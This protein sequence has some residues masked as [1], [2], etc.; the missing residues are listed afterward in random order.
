M[1]HIIT[2]TTTHCECL[3]ETHACTD[4][5]AHTHTHVHA[6][7]LQSFTH[8]W[9]CVGCSLVSQ[10]TGLQCWTVQLIGPPYGGRGGGGR[11]GGE[12]REEREEGKGRG[13]RGGTEEEGEAGG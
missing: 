4:T 8:V 7:T 13:K 11:E 10:Q 2:D 5:H 6:D 1:S 9:C 12:E 3:L